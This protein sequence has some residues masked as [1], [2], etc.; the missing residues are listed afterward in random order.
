MT[1]AVQSRR[2]PFDAFEVN[3]G[4]CELFKHGIRI[5]LQDQPFQ[6]LTILLCRPASWSWFLQSG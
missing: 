6:I 2:V 1:S 5:K 4:S 3:L